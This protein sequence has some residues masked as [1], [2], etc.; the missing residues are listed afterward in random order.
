MKF[1]HRMQKVE[2]AVW[3]NV[4]QYMPF[5]KNKMEAAVIL[6]NGNFTVN[7]HFSNDLHE[8]YQYKNRIPYFI[9]KLH[10]IL[11]FDNQTMAATVLKIEN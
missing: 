7:P 2:L 8:I 4:K 5:R 1:D 3:K 10:K 11:K 6:L 9:R